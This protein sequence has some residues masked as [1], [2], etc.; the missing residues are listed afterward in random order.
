[1]ILGELLIV[2]KVTDEIPYAER[3]DAHD[4]QDTA[5]GEAEEE[6]HHELD[7]PHAAPPL[8]LPWYAPLPARFAGAQPLLKVLRLY[9]GFKAYP[10]DPAPWP[11]PCPQVRKRL[12]PGP[13]DCIFLA[14]KYPPS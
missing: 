10:S 3:G 13:V 11:L 8:A 7:D 14:A 5:H 2:G 9:G 12:S 6:L 1:L 4:H